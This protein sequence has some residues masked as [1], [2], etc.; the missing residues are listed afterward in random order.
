M[1][2]KRVKKTYS[3]AEKKRRNRRFNAIL[4][5]ISALLIL[6]GTILILSDQTLIFP[7]IANFFSKEWQ[8]VTTGEEP[9]MPTLPPFAM[10]TL[11]PGATLKPPE[12]DPY[13]PSSTGEPLTLAP[14]E[15]PGPTEDPSITYAPHE[16][17]EPTP[18]NPYAPKNIYFLNDY[19]AAN[20]Q[21][22]VC[23]IDAVGYNSN[24]QMDTSHSAFRAAWFMY[25][26]DPAHGGNTIIAGHNRYSGKMGY[27]SIIQK[28]KLVSGDI[29]I[30][31]MY[32]G[33]FAYYQVDTVNTYPYDE[34]PKTV[35]STAGN[36]R[37]TLITC[38]GDYSSL[39]HTSRHR[40]IAICYPVVFAGGGED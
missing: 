21:D 28:G 18:Y 33:E 40:V 6:A 32:N 31:E 36:P 23:P 3:P 20:I 11:E 22:I 5:T 24:G 15:T 16:T 10:V 34:V 8:R 30:V 13:S 39:I 9:A 14:G 25:G 27:F 19:V 38:L 7:N 35:M 29:V 2:A 4:Y 17:P 37:L 1:A 26:G 12:Y